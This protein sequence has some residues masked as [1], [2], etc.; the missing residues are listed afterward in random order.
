MAISGHLLQQDNFITSA[1]KAIDFIRSTLFKNNRLLATYKDGNAHLMAYLDDYVFLID[2]ILESLQASW[3]NRD[4]EFA[5]QLADIVMQHFYDEQN[6]GFYFTANDHESLIL[7]PKPLM[8]EAIPAGNGIA[9]YA[10]NRLGHLIGEQRYIDAT[11]KT[12]HYAWRSI[13]EIP[14]AHAALLFSLDEALKPPTI[15]IIRGEK[16]EIKQ[17]QQTCN[18]DYQ[19]NQLVFAIPDSVTQLPGLLQ[20]KQAT[21]TSCAYFCS[22][23]SCKPLITDIKALRNS[24]NE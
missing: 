6:G 15:V 13:A 24:F 14:H 20:D 1:H 12:L 5:I 21:Q 16:S 22:G 3:R 9:A 11:E 7:R 18:K 17:W 19:L 10:L 4:I 8:D 2:A 23:T